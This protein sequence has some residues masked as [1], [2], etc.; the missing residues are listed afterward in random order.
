MVNCLCSLY[1]DK[2]RKG[3]VLFGDFGARRQK[4]WQALSMASATI[5]GI[6]Q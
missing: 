4:Y 6:E 1:I 3:D 2:G 5:D